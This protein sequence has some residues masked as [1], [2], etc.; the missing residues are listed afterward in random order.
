MSYSPLSIS[1]AAH[2]TI[3][4]E[5]A[6]PKSYLWVSPNGSDSNNGSEG[7]PLRTV[8]AAVDRAV[9]G[10]AVMLKAGAYVEN[11][12]IRK[13]GAVDAPIWLVSADGQ[14]AARLIA[15]DNGQTVLRAHGEDNWIIKGLQVEG[16]ANGIQFSMSGHLAAA[17]AQGETRNV[18]IQ[19]NIIR[20]V[21]GAD[22]IKISQAQNFAIVGNR[23]E[24]GVGQEGIDLVYTRNSVVSHNTIMNTGGLAGITVKAGSSDVKVAHNYLKGLATDGILVGGFSTDQGKVWPNGVNYEARNI[25]VEYNEI[26]NVG[27]RA[28]NVLDGN[29]SV[30]R[31]NWFDPQ[32]NYYTVASVGQD[33]HGWTS[34]NIQFINNITSRAGWLSVEGG[35]TG[36]TQSG[37][38]A[39][40]SWSYATGTGSLPG[41]GTTTPPPPVEPPAPPTT[42]PTSP[43]APPVGDWKASAAWTSSKYGSTTAGKADNVYGDGGHNRLDGRSGADTMTGY[44]GDDTYVVGSTYDK[45][46]ERAGEGVDTVELWGTRWTMAAN[47]ENLKVLQTWD[48]PVVTDNQLDNTITA[49]AATA[50]T[51]IFVKENGHDL[52][53]GFTVGQD[54]L[55][56]DPAVLASQVEVHHHGGNMILELP[57]DNSITLVGV[58]SSAQLQD[59]LA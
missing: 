33:N 49:Q 18:V 4:F 22:G 10:T 16:G 38:V 14:G 5:N 36:I 19:D 12:E 17:G 50:D 52:L 42:D 46:V 25:T 37:N 11:V 57:G 45:V 6:K 3:P 34:S 13:D 55:R 47:V 21:A 32:N 48:R 23:I 51:F 44:K 9:P 28:V 20:N 15:R 40:G 54:K 59:L 31:N 7:A 43:Y 29:D 24:G 8:Q 58:A 27:K 2:S 39:T 53:R 41:G 26:H 35:S 56:L 1:S 30:I